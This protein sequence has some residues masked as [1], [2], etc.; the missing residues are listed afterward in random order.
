[1]KKI[2]QLLGVVILW[3][4]IYSCNGT[5]SDHAIAS[6]KDTSKTKRPSIPINSKQSIDSSDDDCDYYVDETEAG[7]MRDKYNRNFNKPGLIPQ[8]WIEKCVLTAVHAYLTSGAEDYDGIRFFL[9][10]KKDG[11]KWQSTLQVIPTLRVPN[12]TPSE[13]H[14]NQIGT[15]IPLPSC[16]PSEIKMNL[17]FGEAQDM[18]D[19]FGEQF[20][21]ERSRGQRNPAGV[22]P[23]SIGIWL[24]KCKIEKLNK[25]FTE[26]GELTGLMA[27][28]A[29]YYK[30]DERR[31]R[32]ERKYIVQ[33]T[34]L[35]VPTTANKALNWKIVAPV[36]K[37]D[38]TF[39][40]GELCPDVCN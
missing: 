7:K 24:S 35:L 12:P 18:I 1:V 25:L 13:R 14:T 36:R 9:G 19:D 17:P 40:H 22:D 11:T 33:T 6:S 29:A 28:A 20:R 39:N 32:R 31:Q 30:D 5:S 37:T 27:I 16:N 4:S 23:L 8:F 15:E 10:A 2:I 38:E 34:M 3:G 21:K 26:H